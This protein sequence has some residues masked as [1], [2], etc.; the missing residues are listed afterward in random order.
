MQLEQQPPSST[1]STWTNCGEAESGHRCRARSN[2]LPSSR[3]VP[4]L[5]PRQSLPTYA[6]GKNE[7]PGQGRQT[8]GGEET[9]PQVSRQQPWNP[10]VSQQQPLYQHRTRPQSS[11]E[12]GSSL[13]EGIGR[14]E[15]RF[16]R[17][18]FPY[19]NDKYLGPQYLP[20]GQLGSQR[21][22]EENEEERSSGEPQSSRQPLL[23]PDVNAEEPEEGVFPIEVLLG[24]VAGLLT[25]LLLLLAVVLVVLY[26]RQKKQEV[27]TKKSLKKEEVLLKGIPSFPGPKPPP[28]PP[29]PL[30]R[31]PDL[32]QQRLPP[33]PP[34]WHPPVIYALPGPADPWL[35]QQSHQHQHQAQVHR[36]SMQRDDL[37]SRPRPIPARPERQVQAD[38]H[39]APTFPPKS[40][41][42]HI[43]EAMQPPQALKRSLDVNP[44]RVGV[45]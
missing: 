15:E 11:Q 16:S 34:S 37:Q 30:P 35:H 43:E 31:D 12:G 4:K 2:Q 20:E 9:A 1:W 33:P 26:R 14:Q 21:Q 18:G 7:A 13:H 44:P 23:E 25:I 22:F 32:H 39:I 5:P 8:G 41:Q 17:Q 3:P 28:K 36:S 29:K 19:Q 40:G 10:S 27:P 38:V 45:P 42:Q 24:V 6:G